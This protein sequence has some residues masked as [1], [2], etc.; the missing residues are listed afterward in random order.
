MKHEKRLHPRCSTTEAEFRVFSQGAKV[1]GRLANIGQKGLA[2]RYTPKP[3]VGANFKRID[4][5]RTGPNQWLLPEVVC[6]KTYDISVLT[7][8]QTF[9]G[10]ET[11]L[12]GLRF[13]RLTKVQKE[14]LAILL[15]R[16]GR[17]SWQ[18]HDPLSQ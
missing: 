1:I 6:E 9:T 7:E 11:R 13:I 16:C 17:S 8:N 10:S 14:R 4:I 2:F 3:G 12:C 18:Y 5:L 15:E